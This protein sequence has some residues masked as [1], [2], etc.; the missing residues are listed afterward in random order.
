MEI[1]A[2]VT[3]LYDRKNVF[4]KDRVTNETVYQ[5]P[6]MPSLGVSLYF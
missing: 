1:N 5:L 6:I 3:N 4:Y 2:S